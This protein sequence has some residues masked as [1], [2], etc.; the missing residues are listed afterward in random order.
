MWR[1]W[2]QDENSP[3][4]TWPPSSSLLQGP[5]TSERDNQAATQE[6]ALGLGLTGVKA[7]QSSV[8]TECACYCGVEGTQY[9]CH[10]CFTVSLDFCAH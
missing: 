5:N 10:A 7:A 1:C 8:I 4:A 6:P 2:D 3:Y 9:D